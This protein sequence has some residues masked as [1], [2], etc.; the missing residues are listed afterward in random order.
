MPSVGNLL[1]ES[2]I[3]GSTDFWRELM[4]GVKESDHIRFPKA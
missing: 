2:L 4:E 3:V 1:G